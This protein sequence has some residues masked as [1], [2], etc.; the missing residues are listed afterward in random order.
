MALPNIVYFNWHHNTASFGTDMQQIDMGVN[1]IFHIS[2]KQIE[3]CTI[4]IKISEQGNTFSLVI[5]WRFC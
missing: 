4:T 1:G 3:G 5:F 2:I